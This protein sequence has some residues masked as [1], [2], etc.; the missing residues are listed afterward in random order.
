MQRKNGFSLIELMIVVAIIGILAS[1]AI[2][3]FIA[4]QMKAKR[5]EVPGNL[6]G[7]KV[8]E[9]AYEAAFN[10]YIN[11]ATKP[12]TIGKTAQAWVPT[13]DG[14]SSI[15]WAPDGMVRGAYEVTS[16]SMTDFLALGSCDVDGDGNPAHY[17]VSV[18]TDVALASADLN[19]Y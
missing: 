18:N 7:I 19:I 12:A 10:S 13:T 11:A 14:F 6:N 17:S 9:L 8:S 16:A 5:S 1:I 4:M 3:N 2:P 15:G